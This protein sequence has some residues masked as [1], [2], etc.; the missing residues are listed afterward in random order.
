[1]ACRAILRLRCQGHVGLR[2]HQRLYRG[3][4][5][6]RHFC[7][8]ATKDAGKA[9]GSADSQESESDRRHAETG[10]Y[11]TQDDSKRVGNPIMW[12]NPTGGATVDDKSHKAW[13]WI[14]P[15]GV[16][17]ILFACLMSR[18]RNLRKEQEESLMEAPSINLSTPSFETPKFEPMSSA[19]FA[20][21]LPPE[22]E[23]A[24]GEHGSGSGS[25]ST[26][27]TGSFSAP[28]ESSQRW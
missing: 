20:S 3:M 26:T 2:A 15:L 5:L 16:G 25:W 18:R 27:G 9:S 12:A 11:D 10:E 28:P 19:D 24:Y 1:M 22:H 23:S 17:M 4:P 7:A 14:Y 6:N 21:T 8:D 13:R